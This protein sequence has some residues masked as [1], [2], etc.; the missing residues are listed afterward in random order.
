MGR[1]PAR[2]H[3]RQLPWVPKLSGARGQHGD[4]DS[5]Q[6]AEPTS[7]ASQAA[8]GSSQT[9]SFPTAY[10]SRRGDVMGGFT[11]VSPRAGAALRPRPRLQ[12]AAGD[13]PPR[14]S[15]TRAQAHSANCRVPVSFAGWR[16]QAA[17]LH[18]LHTAPEARRFGSRSTEGETPRDQIKF[19]PGLGAAERVLT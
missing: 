5:E 1:P 8:A 16:A 18:H 10:A 7:P 6:L 3:A 19:S 15:W 12:R 17:T 9:Y 11:E 14:P 13:A 4:R 2:R